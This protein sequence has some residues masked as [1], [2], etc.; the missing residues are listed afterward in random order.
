[1]DNVGLGLSSLVCWHSGAG[2]EFGQCEK[3]HPD[4]PVACVDTTSKCF[5]RV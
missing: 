2:L 1:M 5:P 4:L 3:L